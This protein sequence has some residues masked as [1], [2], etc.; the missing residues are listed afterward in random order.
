M[1]VMA[2]VKVESDVVIDRLMEVFRSVGYDGASMAQL[3]DA[4]G[5]QKASLYHRFPGGKQEMATAVLDHVSEWNQRQ[6]VDVLY[7]SASPKTRLT[8]ALRS[9]SQLYDGGR[10]ACILRALS[11]GT[12]ADLFRQPI[13]SI[14]TKW[15]DAFAHLAQDL[16][17]DQ[18][19]SRHLG[20]ST[21]VRIQGSLIL[22]QTLNQ[23]TLF[24]QALHDIETDFLIN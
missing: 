12:A 16:G 3:A 2:N 9:I 6:L 4:T 17:F 23:P 13:A 1:D 24:E 7:S 14:F 21:L 22:A 15:V 8:T 11:H 10:L 5:L 18:Q 20:E 19:T